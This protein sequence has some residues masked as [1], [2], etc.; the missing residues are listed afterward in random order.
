MMSI[1][2]KFKHEI[3]KV[4]VLSF[5]FSVFFIAISYFRFAILKQAEVPYTAFGFGIIRALICAK[6]MMISQAIYPIRLDDGKPAFAHIMGRSFLYVGL[7]TAL[8]ALEEAIR[9]RIHGEHILNAITG[10]RP[11]TIHLF[12][13][14]EILYWLMVIP[15]VFF[16]VISQVYGI[17]SLGSI[18]FNLKKE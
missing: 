2:N 3:I 18:F 13:S 1:I 17:S 12:F 4:W 9:A 8:I 14:L 16:T 15:Y 5:Y 6:F 7:V 11:G 10:L